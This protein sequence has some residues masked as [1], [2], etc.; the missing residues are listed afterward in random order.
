MDE[1]LEKILYEKY[2]KIFRQK[3]L[4]AKETCMCWGCSCENGWF[5]LIDKTCDQLQS[6]VDNKKRNLEWQ[7][8]YKLKNAT[9]E[10]AKAKIL[11]EYESQEVFQVE[12]AQ[13]KQKF[14]GLRIYLD[15][16][17]E[18][19]KGVVGLAKALSY[20]ICE[21]CG[22]NH[23]VKMTT[24]WI[25]PLCKSCYRKHRFSQLKYKLLYKTGIIKLRN[26]WKYG[27]NPYKKT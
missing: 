22:S 3:D 11:A 27:F 15:N 18:Y 25:R 12:A 14:G 4:S 19:C 6:H 13:V 21:R 17:D 10:E 16:D 2:P 23:K 26:W 20:G 9:T 8:E 5:N 7:R 1:K 24:G